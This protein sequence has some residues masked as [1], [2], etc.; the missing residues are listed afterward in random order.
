MTTA[1]APT[2]KLG[3]A[4]KT[5]AR[6]HGGVRRSSASGNSW[7][8]NTRSGA[9]RMTLSLTNLM[10]VDSNRARPDAEP[11]ALQITF[12]NQPYR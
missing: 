10:A 5:R 1:S 4:F 6:S 2:R 11:L 3:A 8:A 7:K 9:A 12:Q